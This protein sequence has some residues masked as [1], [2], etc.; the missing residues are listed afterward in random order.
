[1][2]QPCRAIARSLIVL[3]IFAL[4]LPTRAQTVTGT[5]QGT[6]TDRTSATLPGVTIT[7]KNVE[8]GLERI[9][10]TTANGFFNAPFLQIGRYNVS[11]ELSGFGVQR[12]QNVRVDLNQTAV[13]DFILDPAMT[14]TVTVSGESPMLEVSKPS[15]ILNFSGD[16]QKQV[17]IEAR[18][19]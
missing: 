11:A 18:R 13:Q 9:A 19:N 2:S 8:T 17:P 6:V 1:M 4:S 12:H 7:M 16:F 14:E 5:I 3:A 10:V 15:N